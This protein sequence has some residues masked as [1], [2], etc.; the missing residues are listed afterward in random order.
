MSWMMAELVIY[1]K[2]N[3]LGLCFYGT[4]TQGRSCQSPLWN[5]KT[6]SRMPIG[7]TQR[8]KQHTF[9]VDP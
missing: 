8:V 2:I 5:R 4:R 3:C 7:V 1:D 9:S 6:V